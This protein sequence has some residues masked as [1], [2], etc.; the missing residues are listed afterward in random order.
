MGIVREIIGLVFVGLPAS[1]DALTSKACFKIIV[2][3]ESASYFLSPRRNTH[4]ETEAVG[5]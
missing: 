1:V 2:V 5:T 3:I 4:P